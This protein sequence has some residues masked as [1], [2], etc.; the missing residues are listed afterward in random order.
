MI[1]EHLKDN[2]NV[3]RNRFE[4][5]FKCTTYLSFKTEKLYIH[6]YTIHFL[7]DNTCI[8][9]IKPCRERAMGDGRMK[10]GL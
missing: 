10:N 7:L 9:L 8:N 6:F 2:P 3:L 1:F 5:Q 4:E